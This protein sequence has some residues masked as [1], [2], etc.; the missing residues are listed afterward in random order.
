M[1][2]ERTKKEE[3][4]AFHLK[5]RENL[6]EAMKL[7]QVLVLDI[8]T[9]KICSAIV[10]YGQHPQHYQ[11]RKGMFAKM[12]GCRVNGFI[13]SKSRGV[14]NGQVV[15]PK[16]AAKAIS[17]NIKRTFE[18]AKTS[19]PHVVISYSGQVLSSQ[20]YQGNF[21]LDNQII[22]EYHIAKAISN[23]RVSR[24]ILG[25][26]FLHA[27]P[28]NFSIDH[29]RGLLDP[30]GKTGNRLSADVH[31]VTVESKAIEGIYD[32]V[33]LC[34]LKVAGIYSG[35]YA[36]GLSTLV[37]NEQESGTVIVNIG[38]SVTNISGFIQK[39]MLITD[40]FPIGS[41]H[42]T[43]DICKAFSITE[44]EAEYL[45]TL[46]GGVIAT[47][48]DDKIKC[49][50]KNTSYRGPTISKS[51]LIG[52][53]YPRVEEIL[54]R[55]DIVLRS[56]EWGSNGN[57]QIVFT[58]GGSLLN[59]LDDFI[60]EKFGHGIRIARPVQLTGFPAEFLEP[61]TSA[62]V[63]LCLLVTQP[64]DEA[65]DFIQYDEHRPASVT[66]QLYEFINWIQKDW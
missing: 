22:A 59:G 35:G 5:M 46:Y 26:E 40:S 65:W 64:Q 56:F 3:T 62:L 58:G 31:V 60:R 49:K 53:I 18:T 2:I 6:K 57:Q 30:R 23:C 33:K 32:A 52:V 28:V 63:G 9:S 17:E 55:I 24:L 51:H 42:I 37:E 16:E 39:H 20:I 45:K 19:C 1:D 8:G 50:L 11:L 27:H 25:Q 14:K 7:G 48:A 66:G 10:E 12:L 4:F 47:T 21:E 41:G 61:S 15:D 38:H 36:S 54:E 44:E 13:F 29:R 43:N 34:G